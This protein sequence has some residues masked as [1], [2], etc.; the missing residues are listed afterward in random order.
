MPGIATSRCTGARSRNGS[1]KTATIP[2]GRRSA[3][4]M[5]RPAR[6]TSS[7]G[8]NCWAGR[9]SSA[10]SL[11]GLQQRRLAE[12]GAKRFRFEWMPRRRAVRRE[13][14]LVEDRLRGRLALTGAPLRTQPRV[15][16]LEAVVRIEDSAHDELW[17]DGAVPV[18]LLQPERD[19]V[20]TDLPEAV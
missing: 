14:E 5:K 17:R 1:R 4:D 11:G 7:P 12:Q 8:A 20:A 18:V 19:V 3:D 9:S 10:E 2:T 15:E 6:G 13:T 16:F